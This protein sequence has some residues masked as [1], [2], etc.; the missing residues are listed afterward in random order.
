ML[1]IG[2]SQGSAAINLAVRNSLGS[3]LKCYDIIHVCGKGKLAKIEKEGYRE[4]EFAKD[5]G[6]VY[7]VTDTAISR[8]GA[9]TLFELVA[10]KIPTLAIPLPKGNSR[11]DQ[12][13]NAEYFKDNGLIE[14]LME[15]KLSPASLIGALKNLEEKREAIIN[16]CSKKDY[17]GA[18][19]K[20]AKYIKIFK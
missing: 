15:E 2:G 5:I 8:A 13:E 17:R 7:A 1:V 20:I 4:I 14:A 10:L 3:L 12:V 16:N 19:K 11:G 18:A 9:N 6:E